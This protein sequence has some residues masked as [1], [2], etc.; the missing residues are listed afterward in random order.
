[1]P[2]LQLCETMLPRPAC[3]GK[4]HVASA[5]RRCHA[6]L[7][8]RRLPR[9]PGGVLAGGRVEGLTRRTGMRYKRATMPSAMQISRALMIAATAVLTL[10][11]DDEKSAPTAPSA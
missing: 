2:P 7:L 4:F 5:L 11:C 3:A 8:L 9:R 1:M 6:P 10:A